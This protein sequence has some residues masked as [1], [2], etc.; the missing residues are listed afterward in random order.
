MFAAQ[1]ASLSIAQPHAEAAVSRLRQSGTRL[2]PSF[3]EVD[4]RAV[5]SL[6]HFV[7]H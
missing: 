3:R 4:V 5:R 2:G 1:G 7:G 6:L